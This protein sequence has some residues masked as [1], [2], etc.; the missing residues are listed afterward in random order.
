MHAV[1]DGPKLCRLCGSAGFEQLLVDATRFRGA[2][3]FMYL[4]NFD[5][6]LKGDLLSVILQYCNSRPLHACSSAVLQL[7]LIISGGLSVLCKCCVHD[8]FRGNRAPQIQPWVLSSDAH[9]WRHPSV[10]IP[11]SARVRSTFVHCDTFQKLH[12]AKERII[13]LLS[14]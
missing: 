2:S 8:F 12:L 10:C 3:Q 13:S 14:F 1:A 5:G 4:S 6:Y 7:L 11:D 9:G